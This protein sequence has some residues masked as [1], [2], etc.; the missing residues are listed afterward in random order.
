MWPS[1]HH[2]CR[3]ADGVSRGQRMLLLENATLRVS[4][5]PDKGSDIAGFLHKPSDTDPLWRSP[6]P[7]PFEGHAASSEGRALSGGDP[8]LVFLDSYHG[9]WQELFPTCGQ[10][11]VV[12][13]RRLPAHGEVFRLPWTFEVEVDHPEEVR[14]R[15]ETRTLTGP[16]LLQKWLTIRGDRPVLFLRERVVLEGEE[17]LSFM[18]GHHPAFG[19]PFLKPGCRIDSDARTVLT[20]GLHRDPMARLA[21]DQRSPWPQAKGRDGGIVDL[22]LLPP[23]DLRVHDWAYLGDFE[24]GWVALTDPSAS[25]GFAM[26]WTTGVMPYLLYWQNL[27]GAQAEPYAGRS[28]TVGLEPHSTFP[29]DHASGSPLLRLEPGEQMDFEMMATVYQGLDRVRSVG[30]DGVVA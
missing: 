30:G 22:S 15:L 16:F 18:W 19:A 20:S 25:V 5:L 4:L 7:P 6:W 12:Q 2:G 3:W 13:G 26:R 21:P 23:A 1:R 8:D 17:P 24:E 9:G 14:L 29:A 10:P 27:W 11:A 28:Y